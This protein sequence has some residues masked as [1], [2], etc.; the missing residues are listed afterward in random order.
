MGQKLTVTVI[1]DANSPSHSVPNDGGVF[2]LGRSASSAANSLAV[3]A[4]ST[5]AGAETF[6]IYLAPANFSRSSADYTL[7][8][9]SVTLQ[10]S[11]PPSG[12]TRHCSI[13]VRVE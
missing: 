3:T 13:P 6:A 12:I 8:T 11:S 10:V 9:R 5:S 4:V 7:T 2:A 1:N